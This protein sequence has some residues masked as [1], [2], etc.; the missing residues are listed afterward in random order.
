MKIEL[1]TGTVHGMDRGGEDL[2]LE[3]KATS[4]VEPNPEYL[5]GRFAD[6]WGLCLAS[7]PHSQAEADDRGEELWVDGDRLRSYE[8]AYEFKVDWTIAD[9]RAKVEKVIFEGDW[10]KKLR[11]G[12][13][14]VSEDLHVDG[15]AD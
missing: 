13:Y 7:L 4:D 2:F 11:T 14:E 9:A 3:V 1:A 12:T 8:T 10:V 6:A 5:R 15:N